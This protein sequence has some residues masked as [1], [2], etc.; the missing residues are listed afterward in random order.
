MTRTETSF[1]PIAR[2][3]VKWVG[4]KGRVVPTLL[5]TTP[6]RFGRYHEPFVGGGAFFYALH[7]DWR[8]EQGAVLTDCNLRLVRTFRAVKHDV[9]RLIDRLA[10]LAATHDKDQYYAVRAWDVDAL[11]DDVEVAAW[12]IYLNKTGFNGLYRVNK[13]NGF[14]VPM[15]RYKN[16]RVCDPV[17]LYACSQA[18]QDVELKH[19]SFMTV[20]EDAEPGDLVYF[21]PP[22]VPLSKTASFT[23]YSKDGFG[24]AEQLQLAQLAQE[25]KERGVHVMLSN[26]DTPEVRKLYRPRGFKRRTVKVNRTI[27]SAAGKR[28]AVSEVVYWSPGGR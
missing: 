3:F 27:N 26:H 2:P 1:R 17:N 15:G 4:G 24:P 19:G 22:Y 5:R 18:L 28:G 9:N 20:A 8:L 10:Q 7:N 14:N 23:A 25:L 21:D 16:P 12:F 6:G 13:K 11:D